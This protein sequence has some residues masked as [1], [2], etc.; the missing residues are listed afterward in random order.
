MI[1]S[2]DENVGKLMASLE[3]LGLAN[4]TMVIFTS[5]NG[6]V[7]KTSKQ[8]PLRAGK[9]AYYEGGIREPLFVRWPGKIK[10]GSKTHVP[11]SGVDFFPT[12]VDVAGGNKLNDKVLDGVSLLP[13]LTGK[14]ELKDRA[15]YWHFPIYLQGYTKKNTENRDHKFRTRPGSVIRYGDFK[16]H[17]YFEDGGL[18]LYNLKEDIGEK[19]D[20]SKSNPEKVRELHAM[21]KAWRGKM[22][23]PVPTELNPKYKP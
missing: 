2:L 15:L 1:E 10:A 3:E 5:D 22:G 20:L 19:N 8:W 13:L 17:E 4:N 16:L 14:G 12:L 21:L 11:V 6:G 23:A 7:W 9:G 18:E